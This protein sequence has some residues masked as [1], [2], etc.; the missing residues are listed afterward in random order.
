[1]YLDPCVVP[2]LSLPALGTLIPELPCLLSQRDRELRTHG[3]RMRVSATREIVLSAGA[4]GSP[5]LLLR[6][7]IGPREEL[8]AAGVPTAVD[9]KNLQDHPIVPLKYRLGEEG[10]AWFPKSAGKLSLLLP[11]TALSPST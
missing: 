7:G 10:G 5:H 4:Y 6:S 1:M 2:S 11:S 8:E 3:Q 9:G